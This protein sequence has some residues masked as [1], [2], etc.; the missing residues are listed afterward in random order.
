MTIK[1][2]TLNNYELTV[3]EKERGY[4]KSH[5]VELTQQKEN[6][7]EVEGIQLTVDLTDVND[8]ADVCERFYN[9]LGFAK[10]DGNP[11][12]DGLGDYLWYFPESSGAFIEIN[13]KAVHL[14]VV[15]LNHVWKISEKYYS[16]LCEILITT[17]DNSRFDDGFRMIVEVNNFT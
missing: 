5:Q 3:P 15:N 1:P 8:K 2:Y 4:Y 6:L 16:I 11:S 14:R 10:R 12:W 17:T 9:K 7:E 13:P